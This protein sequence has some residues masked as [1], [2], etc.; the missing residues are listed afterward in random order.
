MKSA[1][2]RWFAR[3]EMCVFITFGRKIIKLS[4]KMLCLHHCL[5]FIVSYSTNKG[6]NIN[7]GQ[8]L[9]TLLV[10]EQR[11][12]VF[13]QIH[14]KC[15]SFNLSYNFNRACNTHIATTITTI[16]SSSSF[17]LLLMDNFMCSFAFYAILLF[18]LLYILSRLFFVAV[19]HSFYLSSTFRCVLFVRSYLYPFFLIT[20]CCYGFC[21][22]TKSFLLVYSWRS[23]K[24]KASYIII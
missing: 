16:R 17:N 23:Q 24:T 15:G 11:G 22:P 1:K 14:I 10:N 2:V 6:I 12:F 4:I 21:A 8:L 7:A 9:L 5:L 20:F 19:A 18:S 13:D 3:R